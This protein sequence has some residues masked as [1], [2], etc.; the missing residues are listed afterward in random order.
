[1][2]GDNIVRI[3]CPNCGEQQKDMGR[4]V[5]CVNCGEQMPEID[6]P[7][8]LSKTVDQI[9]V[10]QARENCGTWGVEA[11]E[12]LLA[13][14]KELESAEYERDQRVRQFEQDALKWARLSDIERVARQAAEHK[15]ADV[16]TRIVAPM[17]RDDALS[18]VNEFLKHH[19]EIVERASVFSDGPY[20]RSDRLR[21]AALT[22]ILDAMTGKKRE[23]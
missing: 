5:S 14:I 17:S 8:S 1:M 4:N 7:V 19:L 13:R 12:L 6:L 10:E 23:Q 3:I 15:L 16:E 20:L 9:T 22:K 2:S 18:L 21:G 11:I